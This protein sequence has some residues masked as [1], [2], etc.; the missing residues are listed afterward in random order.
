[1][2]ILNNN[3]ISVCLAR[4]CN[5]LG[6][7]ARGLLTF[8]SWNRLDQPVYKQMCRWRCRDKISNARLVAVSGGRGD[9]VE[10]CGSR[11]H[12]TMAQTAKA[13]F[14]AGTVTP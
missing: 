1:M 9:A 8:I 7:D 14:C 5:V 13:L 2:M 3:S 6:N 4:V 10:L 12:C 11:G